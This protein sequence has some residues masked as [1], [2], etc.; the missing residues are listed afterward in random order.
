M[1]G[2]ILAAAAISAHSA[3]LRLE[4]WTWKLASDGWL[5]GSAVVVNGTNGSQ[6]TNLR[7]IAKTSTGLIV[8]VDNHFI[9][10]RAGE[11]E[12]VSL[13]AKPVSK[14]ATTSCVLES[15]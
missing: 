8:A 10:L 3:N 9:D 7:C 1:I 14:P 6:Q 11:S 4:T 12:Q 2:A 15:R 13:V 5:D